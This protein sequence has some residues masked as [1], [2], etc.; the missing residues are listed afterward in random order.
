MD[1]GNAPAEF[2]EPRR[3]F[4]VKRYGMVLRG[5]GLTAK[6]DYY[7]ALAQKMLEQANK[8]SDEETK[9]GFLD[10]AAG[11]NDLARQVDADTKD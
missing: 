6:A 10:L 9:K 3:N 5:H 2:R 1:I 4:L 11:W 7:R 8:A